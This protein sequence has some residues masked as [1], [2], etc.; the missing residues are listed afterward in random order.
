VCVS[1]LLSAA[2][3]GVKGPSDAG[4]EETGGGSA[5]G[6]GTATGGGSAS[7]G[8]A[9]TGG[10][11]ATPTVTLL[12]DVRLGA[13][14]HLVDVY[15]PSNANRAVVFLHGG[16]GSKEGGAKNEIV[17]ATDPGDGG[18]AP[19]D[20][21]LLASE[22][23]FILPQGQAIAGA[24]KATTWNNYVMTSGEDDV[25]FLTAL[26]AAIRAG[27]LSASVPAFSRVYVGGHSNGGMMA[28]RMWCEASS[29]FDSY[30]AISGPASVQLDIGGAHPCQ[31]SALRPFLSIVGDSDTIIQSD[32]AWDAGAW[33]VN[34]CLQGTGGSFVNPAL[35]PDERF[36][37]TVRVPTMCGGASSTPVSS[38]NITTWSDCDGG[39][40]LERIVGAD[41]CVVSQFMVCRNNQLL[42]GTCS[43]SIEAQSG[44]HMRDV[45]L[46]F[47]LETAP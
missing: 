2:C 4:G 29:V 41:H 24:A 36:Y 37:E 45:L 31:P 35:I 46:D 28:N 40:R 15:L 27:S 12:R 10:G 47:F 21:W 22:T 19:D 7:G 26:S 8:G 20:T 11:S 25:V 17:I 38:G 34:T 14:P 44:V 9:A 43:N 3:G 42:G 23:A 6:G 33:G 18:V 30:A 32:G 13:D 1:L 39:V 16:G 5:I